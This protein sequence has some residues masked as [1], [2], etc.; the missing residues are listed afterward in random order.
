M[1][2]EHKFSEESLV[3]LGVL[4]ERVRL[5]SEVREDVKLILGKVQGIELRLATV[6]TYAAITPLEARLTALESGRQQVLG[7]W[8]VLSLI[9]TLAGSLGSFLTWLLHRASSSTP[10]SGL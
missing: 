10:H 6:P 7:G 1:S 4:Q 3:E 9:G 5:F 8:K 2:E